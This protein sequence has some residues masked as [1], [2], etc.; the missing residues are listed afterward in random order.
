MQQR[1]AENTDKA[2]SL[3]HLVATGQLLF[4]LLAAAAPRSAAS[5]LLFYGDFYLFYGD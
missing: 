1:G 2:I 3:G 4:L 5:S